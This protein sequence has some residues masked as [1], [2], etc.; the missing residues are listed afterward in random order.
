M[1]GAVSSPTANDQLFGSG[2]IAEDN[3]D[4]IVL[5]TFFPNRKDGVL[6]E[7]GAAH[8]EYLSISAAFRKRGWKIIAVEPNPEFCSL[9]HARG[10]EVLEYACSE[11]DRDDVDFT[12]VDSHG[13]DYLGGKVSA[14]SMSSLGVKDEFAELLSR[15]EGRATT[16]T[17]SVK[18]RKLDTILATHAPDVSSVQVVCVDVEGWELSVM[19]GFSIGRY[20]PEIVILEN[21]LKKKEYAD[22]MSERGYKRWLPLGLNEVYVRNDL[23]TVTVK[24]RGAFEASRYW[25]AT[26]TTRIKNKMNK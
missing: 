3:V 1:V 20:R 18:V 12:V 9:H 8:P 14:E 24:L 13:V 15:R 19:R 21:L 26:L 17:I 7:I 22:F 23:M 2:G 6:I 10:F 11:E 4:E 5:S 16:K 25:L